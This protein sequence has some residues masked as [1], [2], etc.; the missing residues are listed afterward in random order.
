MGSYAC[1]F[2]SLCSIVE[3][4]FEATEPT[5]KFDILEAAIKCRENDLIDDEWTCKTVEILNLLT[6][7][8]WKRQ[9]LKALPEQVPDNMYTVE[10]W[11]NKR[12]GFTHF[13]RRWGDTLNKSVTVNEG[14][15]LCYYAFTYS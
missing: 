15:L 10:K 2:L 1:L 5:K 7:R 6:G 9:E 11:Y 12:T 3:E 4:F 14:N 13:R 8:N